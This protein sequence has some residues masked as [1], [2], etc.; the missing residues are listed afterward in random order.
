M[1]RARPLPLLVVLLALAGCGGGSP[2][3]ATTAA[4]SAPP[5]AVTVAL[6]GIAFVPAQVTVHVGQSVTWTDEDT[7]THDVRSTS[8][9]VIRSPLLHRGATFSFTPTRA[10]TIAYVCTIHPGMA[11]TIVVTP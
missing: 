7:V 9:E 1:R 8:G 4:P 2:A 10:G 5:A 3:P 11:G 6:S